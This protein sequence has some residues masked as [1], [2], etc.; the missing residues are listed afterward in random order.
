MRAQRDAQALS[1]NRQHQDIHIAPPDLPV[2]PVQ[3]QDPGRPQLQELDH[4]QRQPILFQAARAR[5][6]GYRDTATF[7]TMIHL[8]AAPLENLFDSI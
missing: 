5:A 8:I 6:R 7:I 3:A 4:R 2:R 1:G